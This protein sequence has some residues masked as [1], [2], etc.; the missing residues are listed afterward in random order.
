MNIRP[1]DIAYIGVNLLDVVLTME[2]SERLAVGG[3]FAQTISVLFNPL[4]PPE[5]AFC[6][7]ILTGIELQNGQ[8]VTVKD[9]VDIVNY[10]IG[11]SAT[12]PASLSQSL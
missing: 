3:L 9:A 12:S 4:T 5:K 8:I 2:R 6:R 10:V 1:K 7:D 11:N